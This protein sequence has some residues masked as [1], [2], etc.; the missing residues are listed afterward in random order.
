MGRAS[1]LLGC[2]LMSQVDQGDSSP[3]PPGWLPNSILVQYSGTTTSATT[4][5]VAPTYPRVSAR[6]HHARRN[7]RAWA[8]LGHTVLT[9][10]GYGPASGSDEAEVN[11]L[12]S[13]S[14]RL[15]RSVLY[16]YMCG[17]AGSGCGW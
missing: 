8:W 13:S 4:H 1:L 11:R 14:P 5:C 6:C 12:R 3:C 10:V 9:L 16:E 2:P 15:S 17:K 7:G